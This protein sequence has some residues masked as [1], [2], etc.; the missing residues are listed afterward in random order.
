MSPCGSLGVV[1]RRDL[2]ET[3]WSSLD[4]SVP[5]HSF[6][7]VEQTFLYLYQTKP[8]SKTLPN[9][10]RTP[11]DRILVREDHILASQLNVS[12]PPKFEFPGP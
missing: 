2:L 10:V 9:S 1:L 7:G 8:I 4:F 12:L 3:C 11:Q 5:F 6:N